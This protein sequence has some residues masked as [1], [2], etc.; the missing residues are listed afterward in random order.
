MSRLREEGVNA[1]SRRWKLASSLIVNSDQYASHASAWKGVYD[2]LDE[3]GQGRADAALAESVNHLNMVVVAVQAGATCETVDCEPARDAGNEGVK[4]GAASADGHQPFV[5][6]L[7]TL[8][9]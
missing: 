6:K 3:L 1:A 4:I 8:T 7:W 2:V 9:S 5:Y